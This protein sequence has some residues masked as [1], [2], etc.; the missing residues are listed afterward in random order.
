[1]VSV[2]SIFSESWS[3]SL[4]TYGSLSPAVGD[5][6]GDGYDE[7]VVGV[8]GP[9][10]W[11]RVGGVEVFTHQGQREVSWPRDT[12]LNMMSSPALG[13]LDKDDI[14]DIVICSE[15]EGV[16]AYLS[17]SQD[18]VRG[19]GTRA[20]ISWTLTAPVI[21]DLENDGNLEVLMVNDS[22]TVYA[23]RYNGESVILGNNGFFARTDFGGGAFGFP[24]LVVADLD[25]DGEKE[26]IV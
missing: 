5:V 14:D 12:H 2:K 13:D 18:W 21:A 25:G 26:V 17:A 10:G 16:H 24:C 9:A 1:M 23:W 22:G 15:Q 3:Q 8:G 7:I 6:D 11:E 20:N 4:T 19:A